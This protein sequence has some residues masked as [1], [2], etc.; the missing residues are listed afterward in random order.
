MVSK[1]GVAKWA[2]V[3]GAL[4]AIGT[5]LSYSVS[6][7]PA[8]FLTAIGLMV[9]YPYIQFQNGLEDEENAQQPQ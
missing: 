5:L 3:L 7:R 9:P 8:S 6:A 1:A 4:S 2:F